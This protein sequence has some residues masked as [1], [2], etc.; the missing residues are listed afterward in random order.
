[1][2]RIVDNLWY[3]VKKYSPEI[4]IGLGITGVVSG[5]VVA[6]KETLEVNDILEE[7]NEKIT[8][9]K[10]AS[11]ADEKT[12][13]KDITVTYL[14]TGFKL[15]KLYLPAGLLI[16]GS[17]GCILGSHSIMMKR[18]AGLSAAYIG[19]SEAFN[20]YRKNIIEKYGENADT[21]ARYNV[22]AKKVKGKNGEDDFVEYHM[23]DNTAEHDFTRFFDMDSRYWDKNTN[24]NLITIHSAQSA[25][26]KR[27]KTRR[28]HE[29]SFNEI[30]GELDLR[31]DKELGS[32]MIAKYRPGADDLDE[33]GEP[34]NFE[35][36]V[37]VLNNGKKVKKTVDEAIND[38]DSL[39]PV[40][41]LDFK[42]LEP[43]FA[44]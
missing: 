36:L 18:N 33:H 15:V 9:V 25:I 29:V 31:P 43:L 24:I 20:S 4:L 28:S 14:T 7:H 41:L 34:T 3:T 30:C 1:M 13:S 22:K 10:E 38:G 11:D 12:R 35:I 6:C 16:G 27:L 26:R 42:G 2:N 19:I 8:Q 39:D 37:Y 44:H 23:T 40:M 17:I 21:E 5:T 32:V